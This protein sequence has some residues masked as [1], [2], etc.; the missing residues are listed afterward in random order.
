VPAAPADRAAGSLANA[1][2]PQSE[3]DLTGRSSLG[4]VASSNKKILGEP[5]L[6][7][8]RFAVTAA[9]FCTAVLVTCIETNAQSI[10]KEM[11]ARVEIYAI[12]SLTIS[13]QQFLSG[14]ANAPAY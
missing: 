4:L 3:P 1:L 7:N 14:N 10:P 6:A 12:P 9:I 11:A 8:W 5:M 13:D 2:N